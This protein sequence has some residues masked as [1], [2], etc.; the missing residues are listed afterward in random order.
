MEKEHERRDQTQD[1]RR[2]QEDATENAIVELAQEAVWD[3][4]IECLSC[5]HAHT[6]E[7]LDPRIV[8]QRNPM[9]MCDV[10]DYR[11]CPGVAKLLRGILRT[12]SW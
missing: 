4:R 11:D 2:C 12:S 7:E 1:E 8:P 6:W 9:A 5:P 3:T 10:D